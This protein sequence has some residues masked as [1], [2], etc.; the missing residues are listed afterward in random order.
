MQTFLCN[1]IC[2]GCGSNLAKAVKLPLTM[3][4]GGKLLVTCPLCRYKHICK[5]DENGTILLVEEETP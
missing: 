1:M 4:A 3:G 5:T 2:R